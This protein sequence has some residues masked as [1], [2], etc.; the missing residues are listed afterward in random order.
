MDLEDFVIQAVWFPSR[1]QSVI[2]LAMPC[3]ESGG[4][5]VYFQ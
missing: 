4:K 3:V 1:F 5:P 2:V